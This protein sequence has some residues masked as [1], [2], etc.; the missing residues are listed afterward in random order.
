MEGVLITE[1]KPS[2]LS[3]AL[4]VA[5]YFTIVI[6]LLMLILK[7]AFRLNHRFY[8]TNPESELKRDFIVPNEVNDRLQ[9]LAAYLE[10]PLTHHAD[11]TWL[12]NHSFQLRE[13]PQFIFRAHIFEHDG[14]FDAR[15][16]TTLHTSART[17]AL[18]QNMI[19]AK[20]VCLTHDLDLITI[21]KAKMLTVSIREGMTIPVIVQE[22]LPIQGAQEDLYL[23]QAPYFSKTADQLTTFSLATGFEGISPRNTP[24]LRGTSQSP[25]DCRVAIIS[26]ETMD[27]PAVGIAGRPSLSVGLV[28]CLYSQ[29]QIDRVLKR[30]EQARVMSVEK[31]ILT[32]E[33]RMA[34]IHFAN[35]LRA[36][37]QAR[38]ILANPRQP[39]MV[40][41]AT[42]ELDLEA[43]AEV[44]MPLDPGQWFLTNQA[45][46][47]QRVTMRQVAE[48]VIAE[49]NDR[50]TRS[51]PGTS[52]ATTRFTVLRVDESSLAPYKDLGAPPGSVLDE[53]TKSSLWIY[54]IIHALRAKGHLFRPVT[55]A[56]HNDFH[57]PLIV[58]QESKPQYAYCIQ[59]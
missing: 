38:G 42:L 2:M 16:H 10:R 4:K 22:A 53:S 46:S 20:E 9:E 15:L 25:S 39:L 41:L 54:Q 29:A 30:A 56:D 27:D 33:K 19:R 7:I 49:L 13:F 35:E 44:S 51:P 32:K 6:P 48:A 18:F 14:K 34:Q 8:V 3:S 59:A 55:S 11:V 37:H 17:R 21:P 45:V 58:S 23:T 36:F 52:V 43:T 5:S 57:R 50:M 28:G 24:I 12:S 40:D 26:P 31:S 47:M 1:G